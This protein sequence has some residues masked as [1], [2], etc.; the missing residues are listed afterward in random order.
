VSDNHAV[1]PGFAAVGGVDVFLPGGSGTATITNSTIAGNTG[2]TSI[3]A[4][5]I[6]IEWNGAL[7]A[8]LNNVTISG[9]SNPGRGGLSMDGASGGTVTLSNVIVA[10]NSGSTAPDCSTVVGPGTINSAGNNII[11]NNTGCTLTGAL[12]SDQVGT[13]GSPIDPLLGALAINGGPTQ[14]MALL[15]GSPA[16]DAGN[17]ATCAATDQRGISRPQGPACDIGAFEVVQAPVVAPI[18]TPT[19]SQPLIILLAALLGMASALR[20][21]RR[22]QGAGT[23][24]K[25]IAL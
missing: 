21:R 17:N 24:K 5:G 22:L 2:V 6:D 16:I 13:S 18:A 10:G 1:G 23:K 25:Y 20:L 4:A 12:P 14:T 8:T 11:G 15:A 7:S 19:L 9:N 3:V